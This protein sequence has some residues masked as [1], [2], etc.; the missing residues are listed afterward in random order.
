MHNLLLLTVL[1]L[2]NVNG[3]MW[4]KDMSDEIYIE[5]S[6]EGFNYVKLACGKKRMIVNV[7]MEDDF[8]GIIYT[9]GSF[10]SKPKDCFLDAEDGKEHSLKIPFEKCGVK[11]DSNNFY[12]QELIIQHDDWLIFPGLLSNNKNNLKNRFHFIS[13]LTLF[14]CSKLHRV[15]ENTIWYHVSFFRRFSV[16][17]PMQ[18]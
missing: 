14:R 7:E 5:S 11:L 2:V 18:S 17:N 10:M 15:K 8:D 16:Q 13:F 12:T 1:T 4:E 9:R 3:E 6:F